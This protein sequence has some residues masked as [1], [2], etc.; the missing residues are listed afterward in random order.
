M[1]TADQRVADLEKQLEEE[2]ARA[3]AKESELEQ[4]QEKYT[5]LLGDCKSVLARII[6]AA[7]NEGLKELMD[8][9]TD[10]ENFHNKDLRNY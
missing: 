4:A 9:I 3:D 5:G 2:T 10:A 7:D 1:E 6:D 8:A